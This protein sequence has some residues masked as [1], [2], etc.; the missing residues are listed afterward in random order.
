MEIPEELEHQRR[1][2]QTEAGQ[3][4]N[5]RGAIQFKSGDKNAAMKDWKHAVS[6][7]SELLPAT[8]SIAN[9][10]FVRPHPLKNL[11]LDLC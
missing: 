2:L 5:T 4:A 7:W 10:L 3:I 8:D 11:L 6:I 9:P 1:A